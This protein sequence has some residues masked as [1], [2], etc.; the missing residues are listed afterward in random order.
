MWSFLHLLGE[1]QGRGIRSW[2][3]RRYTPPF[4]PPLKGAGAIEY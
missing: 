1:G 3:V 4:I 2:Y